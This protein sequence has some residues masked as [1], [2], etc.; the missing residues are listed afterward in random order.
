MPEA[1]PSRPGAAAPSRRWARRLS[2]PAL[3]LPAL[4]AWVV[5][6]LHRGPE[7]ATAPWTGPLPA[8]AVAPVASTALVD[9]DGDGL[10]DA[11]EARIARRHAPRYRFAGHDPAGPDAPQNRDE[12]FFPLSVARFR[13][14]VEAGVYGLVDGAVRAEAPGWFEADRIDG[15]PSRL[16]GDPVGEA[17]A[18]VHV[19][20]L[21]AGEAVVEYWLFY[22]YDRADAAVLGVG[23]SLG[24]H[25]GDWEHTAFRVQLDPPRLLEGFYYG[26]A[27]GLQV[28]GDDL[29]RVE[30]EHPVV[31]VSQGKHASY[32]AA[33]VV[34]SVP[35]PTWLVQHLD[36]AN[37]RGPVWDAWRG[38]LVD[39]GERGRPSPAARDW[40]GYAG[41]WGPD[42]LA[43]F[44]LEV[45]A[46][47]TGPTAKPSWGNNVTGTPW[48]DLL[49]E[50][51][52][53][54]LDPGR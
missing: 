3:L 34:P 40:L 32:P 47:P 39:L 8:A 37:G 12:R 2:A 46:S 17:P 20:P 25:R 6:A 43:L 49:A 54:L 26:H 51:G 50:R 24:D 22:G 21:G 9:A 48:R 18:Y 28:A 15:F 52:G 10:D 14:Q 11:L 29:E 44:G 42:G 4:S 33:C 38:P 36:V 7:P 45:G 30:G 41:R 31:Y 1:E 13:A 19:Y 27:L 16:A 5:P 53:W 23:V 35:L